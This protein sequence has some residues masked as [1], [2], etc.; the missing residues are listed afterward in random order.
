MDFETE[1][2]RI[3]T[4]LGLINTYVL[5]RKEAINVIRRARE[6]GE[7]LITPNASFLSISFCIY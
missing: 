6:K 1:L 2:M 4:S 3:E 5:I 7:T